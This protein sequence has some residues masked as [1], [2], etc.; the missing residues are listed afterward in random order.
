MQ[1]DK[2]IR[3][4]LANFQQD[5]EDHLN[6]SWNS[7]LPALDRLIPIFNEINQ[8]PKGRILDVGSGYGCLCSV[9][10]Q[11]GFEVHA[12]DSFVP[13]P[14]EISTKYNIK[15][16]ECNVEAQNIPYGDSF[17]DIVILAH[18][19]ALLSKLGKTSIGSC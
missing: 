11:M 2:T 16:Q 12:I 6:L 4:M 3:E 15:F 18:V 17:F 19:L 7:F 1:I 13:M 10:S 5:F 14:V 9:A 8:L